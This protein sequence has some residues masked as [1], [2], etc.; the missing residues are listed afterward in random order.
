MK[1]Y[2]WLLRVKIAA[3]EAMTNFKDCAVTADM[4]PITL[5]VKGSKLSVVYRLFYD[6]FCR[7]MPLPV[8]LIYR[9]EILRKFL[10]RDA[11]IKRGLSRHAVSVCLSVCVSVTFVHSD[12]IFFTSG[13]PIILVFPHQ[14]GRQQSDGNPRNGGVECK[15]VRKNHDFWPIS[16]FNIL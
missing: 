14:T 11:S 8:H 5:V 12:R 1:L 16:C 13:R 10:P 4:N 3:K 6:A 2:I 15:G 9:R 7:H